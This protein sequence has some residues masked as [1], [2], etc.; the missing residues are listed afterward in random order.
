MCTPS[1]LQDWCWEDKTD[2]RYSFTAV[3]PMHKNHQDAIELDMTRPR[4]AYYKQKWKSAPRYS[5]LGRFSAC[6]TKRIEVLSNKIERSHPLRYTPSVLYLD[7]NCDEI[8][9]NHIPENVCVTSTT[10]D[11]SYKDNWTCNLDSDVARS[12]KDIQRI[13]LRPNTQLSSTGRPCHKTE[14]RNPGTYQVW[15]R[16]S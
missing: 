15:S 9:R 5:V 2:R 4:L 6:S 3:N 16:H 8:W 7:S 14:W 10:A 13:Q 11:D 1:Q 12:S